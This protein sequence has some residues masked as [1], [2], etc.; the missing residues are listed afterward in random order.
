MKYLAM[1]PS[2]TANQ[3]GNDIGFQVAAFSRGD[4]FAMLVKF[5]N[6]IVRYWIQS[7]VRA[8]KELA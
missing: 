4:C 8:E 7:R 2:S 5:V 3:F 6:F 1:R